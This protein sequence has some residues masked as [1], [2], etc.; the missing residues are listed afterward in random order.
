MLELTA[1]ATTD[2]GTSLQNPLFVAGFTAACDLV[3]AGAGDTKVTVLSE[4]NAVA[5]AK[6][7]F[8]KV[9]RTDAD[10]RCSRSPSP[11]PLREGCVEGDASRVG[12]EQVESTRSTGRDPRRP[13]DS[14]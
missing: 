2:G 13:Y 3:A 8:E 6:P 11:R 10:Y 5:R 9:S 14:L 1:V 7:L 4:I 12:V